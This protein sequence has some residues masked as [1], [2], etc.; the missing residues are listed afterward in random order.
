MPKFLV[1]NGSNFQPFTYDE[2]TRPLY[3][4]AEAKRNTQDQYD[5]L[6]MQTEAL[7]NYISENEDDRRAKAMYDNYVSKLRALQE[8]LWSHGYTA[9][10]RR[11]LN[12]ARA[13]FSSDIMRLGKAIENRQARSAEYNK[14]K[15]DHPDMVMGSDPGLDGLD[16]YLNNDLY[17]TDWYQYSG[18]KFTKEVADD[19]GNRVKEM[20]NDPVLSRDIPGYITIKKQQGV[21]SDDVAKAN[22]AVSDYLAGKVNSIGKL[23]PVQT[24][25]ANVL[26]EHLESTGAATKVD[27]S[28]FARLVGYGK[29][30]LS[31]AIGTAD[32]QYLSDKAWDANQEYNDWLRKEK[33]KREWAKKDAEDLATILGGNDVV[34]SRTEEI[35]GDNKGKAEKD[36]KNYIPNNSVTRV[37]RSGDNKG[38][39]VTSN[40]QAAELVYSEDLMRERLNDYGFDFRTESNPYGILTPSKKF[41][42]GKIERNGVTYDVVYK[43]N[44]SVN[45]E[46]GVVMVKKEGEPDYAYKYS[47]ML[48]NQIREDK[49]KYEETKKWY[50][51]NEPE[52]YK[53]A[54]SIDP[55]RRKKDYGKYNEPIETPT[56]EFRG[57]V[58]RR[59]ENS[60]GVDIR[61]TVANRAVSDEMLKRLSTYISDAFDFDKKG[62]VVFD[63]DAARQN[64]GTTYGIHLVKKDGNIGEDSEDPSKVFTWKDGNITNLKSIDVSHSSIYST[65]SA[66]GNALM[67]YFIV[68]TKDGNSYSVSVDLLQS[69][70]IMHEFERA[71]KKLKEL[72]EDGSWMNPADYNMSVDLIVSDLTKKLWDFLGYDAHPQVEGNTSSDNNN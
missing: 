13:G 42:R 36:T 9:S 65:D 25:L 57:N 41:L 34:D 55:D 5:A 15:H 1:T 11:D 43:P 35:V 54:K 64:R 21:T 69:R 61:H 70:T 7:R 63:A 53:M 32:T 58:M 18:N 17:G 20:F 60:V 33:Q 14:F 22:A 38:V 31:A 46:K 71:Q 10:T 26:L 6:S 24:V 40:A 16:N 27:Q 49:K 56:T 59:P 37:V 23:D 19:A 67:P 2:L 30:G 8:N 39:E 51:E 66:S 29:A 12:A 47:E 50:K 45:G 72:D 3:E 68:N 28:E 62:N 48:T 52:I 44:K 4:M